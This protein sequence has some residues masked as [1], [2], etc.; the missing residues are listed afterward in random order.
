MNEVFPYTFSWN[1]WHG[2]HRVS[3]GCLHCYM[4]EGN[5][6]RGLI[7]SE[8]VTK[9]KHQFDLP[10]KKG[11]NGRYILRNRFVMTSM[12]SDFFIEE[13]DGWRDEVWSMIRKRRDLTFEILTKRPE[14]IIDNLPDDWNSGYDNVRISVSAEDQNAWD[15]RIP[16]L[17]SIPS[18][19]RDVFMAPMIGKID[20]DELLKNGG[21]DYI[22]VGGEYCSEGARPCDLN[23]VKAV[24]ESCIANNVSF[25]WRNCGTHFIKNG[26]MFTIPNI[27]EQSDISSAAGLDYIVKPIFDP[28]RET[29]QRNLNDYL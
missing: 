27:K 3:S 10:I 1:P 26:Y 23:W 29:T 6:S 17:Q 2:C 28:G 4:F 22:F 11:K 20:T 24:R 16:I 12:S 25:H 7:T 18:K 19:H 5:E 14:R 9:S 15:R 8:V 21:I 13:A